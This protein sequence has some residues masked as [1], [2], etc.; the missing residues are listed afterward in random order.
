MVIQ[1][2]MTPE[3]IVDVWGD[4]ANIFEKYNVPLTKQPLESIVENEL[5][6]LLLQ[7]LNSVVGS[8]TSTCIEGG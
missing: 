3:A 8:S 1:S 7:E 5:L 6:I 2:N 4:T